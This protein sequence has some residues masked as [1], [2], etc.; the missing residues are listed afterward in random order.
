MHD[1]NRLDG[2]VMSST[3]I[4]Q[5]MAAALVCGDRCLLAHNLNNKLAAIIGQCDLLS[6]QA[7]DP[8]C[9]A[10]LQSIRQTAKAMAVETN[11]HQ[12]NV[13]VRLVDE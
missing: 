3:D 12:C 4:R 10:R 8:E 11:S 9:M 5:N 13:V 1:D 7:S 2:N 6:D